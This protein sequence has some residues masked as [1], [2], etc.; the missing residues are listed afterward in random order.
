MAYPE[1]TYTR[2]EQHRPFRALF[3]GDSFY[4]S[5]ARAGYIGEIFGNRDFWYYD[6]DV[7][8]GNYQ[9]GRL[10]ANEDMKQMLSRQDAVII[11]QTNAGYGELGYY[12]VDRLFEKAGS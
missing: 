12:F 4:F 1:V 11:L 2:T 7:Y 10:A 6:H 8:Y 9:T 3:I 5:W